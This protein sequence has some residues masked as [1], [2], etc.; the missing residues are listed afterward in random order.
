MLSGQD[1]I[2]DRRPARRREAGRNEPPMKTRVVR[3]R[4]RAVVGDT[5][6]GASQMLHGRSAVT[7]TAGCRP[8]SFGSR[9]RTTCVRAIKQQRVAGLGRRGQAHHAGRRT[10]RR[11]TVALTSPWRPL[12][13]GGPAPRSRRGPSARACA[14]KET[15]MR[16]RATTAARPPCSLSWICSPCTHRTPILSSGGSEG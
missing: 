8:R 2:G 11:N 10:G 14:R 12:D 3:V 15:V 7:R 6:H 4:A 16:T 5:V 13:S 9:C 1:A